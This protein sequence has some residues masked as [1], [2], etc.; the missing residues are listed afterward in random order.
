MSA[1]NTFVTK[2][3]YGHEAVRV[4][5]EVLERR[6]GGVSFIGNQDKRAAGFFAGVLRTLHEAPLWELD[7]IL[8]RIDAKLKAI[9]YGLEFDIAVVCDDLKDVLCKQALIDIG[10]RP[11]PQ[12]EESG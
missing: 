7:D 11:N 12:E 9:S 1:R 10:F 8:Q 3:I 5:G 2:M 6:V 4:V